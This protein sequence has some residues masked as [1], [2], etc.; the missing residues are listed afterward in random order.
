MGC[1]VA[2][3]RLKKGNISI[4][5]LKERSK[6]DDIMDVFKRFQNEINTWITHILSHYSVKEKELSSIKTRP[7]T[8]DFSTNAR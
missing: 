4:V 6:D 1:R 3:T 8:A 5:I 2:C 7:G